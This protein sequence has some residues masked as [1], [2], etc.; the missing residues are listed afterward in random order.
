MAKDIFDFS[1]LIDENLSEEEKARQQKE[2]SLEA[3]A[4][5]DD[6]SDVTLDTSRS[7]VQ[8]GDQSKVQSIE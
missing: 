3:Q 4:F 1:G 2:M 5:L 7:T 6:D 8:Q